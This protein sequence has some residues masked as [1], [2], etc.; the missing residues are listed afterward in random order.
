MPWGR[1]LHTHLGGIFNGRLLEG[2]GK[3]R[4]KARSCKIARHGGGL[5]TRAWPPQYPPRRDAGT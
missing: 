5:E 2:K 4:M 3:G 1:M